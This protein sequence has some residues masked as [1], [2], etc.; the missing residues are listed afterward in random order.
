MYAWAYVQMI[1]QFLL[2]RCHVCLN[3]EMCFIAIERRWDRQRSH[4]TILF[5][6]GA[7]KNVTVLGQATSG[8]SGNVYEP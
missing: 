4:V 3:W 6:H 5:D 2:G 7:Y 1:F 8:E